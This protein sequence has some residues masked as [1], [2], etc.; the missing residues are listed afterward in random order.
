MMHLF[1]NIYLETYI[2]MEIGFKYKNIIVP[3]QRFFIQAYFKGATNKQKLSTFEEGVWGKNQSMM[4][5]S[6]SLTVPYLIFFYIPGL[7]KIYL[8]HSR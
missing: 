6:C 1:L 3:W 7:L 8:P 4:F 5:L 2:V